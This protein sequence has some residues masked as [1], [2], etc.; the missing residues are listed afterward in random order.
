MIR[1]VGIAAVVG[2]LAATAAPLWGQ[3]PA[4]AMLDALQKGR[5]ELRSRGDTGGVRSICLRDGREMI[6]LRHQS[7]SCRSLVIEDTPTQVTV[8]YTC[9]GQ[10]YGRTR[11]RRETGQLVQVD[12]QGIVDGSPFAFAAEARWAGNCSR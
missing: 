9:P 12:T 3:R 5:W 11:I 6:Q 2:L 1:R 10:G 4:L 8:Q 7:A